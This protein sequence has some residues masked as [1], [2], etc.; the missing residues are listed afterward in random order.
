MANVLTPVGY[1]GL[2]VGLG[3]AGWEGGGAAA[4]AV[5]VEVP[6]RQIGPVG[7]A[8]H[9]VAVPAGVEDLFFG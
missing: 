1:F 5:V 9:A 2:R 4:V 8:R 6:R 7:V 3:Y